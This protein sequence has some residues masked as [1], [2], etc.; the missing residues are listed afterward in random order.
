MEKP[1]VNKN[2]LLEKYPGKGGWTYAAIP[3]VLQAKNTAFGWVKV[4]GS[5]DGV[6]LKNYR[7]MP[8]GNG[9]LFLPVKAEIRKLIK[10]KEGDLVKIVLFADE[11]PL[12]IPVELLL[13]LKDDPLAY[14]TF[15]S[16]PEGEQKAYINWIFSAKKEETKIERM[17]TTLKRLTKKLKL[18]DK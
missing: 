6:E 11:D 7:L 10:K 8:M 2:Y 15:M 5:I 13:C 3:E 16:F 18:T 14:K 1:L 4:K 12:E 17:A 9:K